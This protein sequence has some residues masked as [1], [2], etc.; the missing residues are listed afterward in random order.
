MVKGKGSEPQ[1]TTGKEE[2]WVKPALTP[3]WRFWDSKNEKKTGDI[4]VGVL[5][6]RNSWVDEGKKKTR[7]TVKDDTGKFYTLFGVT[8]LDRELEKVAD[9]KRIKIVYNGKVET[10]KGGEAHSF[11]VFIQF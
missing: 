6:S 7:Y 2:K 4:F 5:E 11:E 10:K 9:G 8:R 3:I 1:K